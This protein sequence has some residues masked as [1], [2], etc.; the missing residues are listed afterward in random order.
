M[1]VM[2]ASAVG[3]V[4]LAGT[5]FGATVDGIVTTGEYGAPLAI[6]DTPTGFGDNYSELDVAYANMLAG[7]DLEMAFTGNLEG[8]GNGFVLFFDTR[9]GGAVD[10]VLGDGYGLLG[11]FGGARVDDWGGDI[12][13]DWGVTVPPGGPSILDPGFNPDF[14]IEINTNGFDYWTNII[15]MTVP[16][17][18]GQA[19]RD[20]YLGSNTVGG[21]GA[22]HTYWRDGGTTNA[23][24]ITH[25]FDNSNTAGVWGYNWDN[26]PGDLGDPLSA[27]TGFEFLFSAEFLNADPGHEIKLLPFV[28]SG[29]GDYLSNQFLPGLGGAE[30]PGGAGG[31]GGDPLFDAHYFDGDQFLVIPTPGTM[32]LVSLGGLVA[33]KRR[34]S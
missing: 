18:P 2:I 14:A 7:G 16:N 26:P 22:T 33:L 24:D 21:G 8:N 27:I 5:A 6:Q 3:L 17:D 4:A 30:N 29:G 13:G 23:G 11:E 10:T 31:V 12:D 34:R 19:N 1:R 28:T 15:D 20:V 25:A 32:A 9:A